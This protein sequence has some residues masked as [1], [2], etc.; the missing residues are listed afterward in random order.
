MY[1]RCTAGLYIVP[2][3]LTVLAV[4]LQVAAMLSQAGPARKL[5][6]SQANG[7]EVLPEADPVFEGEVLYVSGTPLPF[8]APQSV[9]EQIVDAAMGMWTITVFHS[10]GEESVEQI[11]SRAERMGLVSNSNIF[12][13]SAT[14]MD[15]SDTCATA[16]CASCS[17]I[18]LAHDGDLIALLL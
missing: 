8:V 6:S 1:C 4:P 11:G 10:A 9:T 7:A 3:K 18:M 15:V 2:H 16:A 13:Y 14:R 17:A 12:L 5:S